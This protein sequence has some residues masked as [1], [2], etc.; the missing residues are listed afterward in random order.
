MIKSVR[1]KLTLV[2][3]G[4]ITLLV[5]IFSVF[6]YIGMR[7]IL[8]DNLDQSLYSGGK[9]LEHSI[10][11]YTLKHE[12]DPKSLYEPDE[13]GDT[14]FV[15]DI[16]EEVAELFFFSTVYIQ[17]QTFADRTRFS[18]QVVAKTSTLRDISLPLSQDTYRKILKNQNLRLRQRRKAHPPNLTCLKRRKEQFI[19]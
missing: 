3:I 4:T 18:S 17:L 2:Y 6:T 11:E 5:L 10:A 9:S 15:D 14:F 13:E 8:Q 12:N 16:N 19:T 7:V 1:L